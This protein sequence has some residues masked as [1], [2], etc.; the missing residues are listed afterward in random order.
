M[1]LH[2][3]L[4]LL[5]IVG[6]ECRVRIPVEW[7]SI[8]VECIEC[9]HGICEDDITF[10]DILEE[11]GRLVIKYDLNNWSGL[12]SYIDDEI[13]FANSDI[14]K[15]EGV[16]DT[17][18]CGVDN[19]RCT[20]CGIIVTKY[21]GRMID[22]KTYCTT[23][24]VKVNP[25]KLLVI[26]KPDNKYLIDNK[27]Q[28]KPVDVKVLVDRCNWFLRRH[29]KFNDGSEQMYFEYFGT[30]I[31]RYFEHNKELGVPASWGYCLTRGICPFI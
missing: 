27:E 4:K 17:M 30:K 23:C 9:I 19:R 3:H 2:T 8:V 7:E 10:S 5:H 15:L 1:Y 13:Y 11:D 14:K 29:I 25:P 6:N 18:L 31:C 12:K 16:D 24:G 20:S 21:T 26:K 22:N 28:L